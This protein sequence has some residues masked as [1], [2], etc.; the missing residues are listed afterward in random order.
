VKQ[1]KYQQDRN[2]TASRPRSKK[3]KTQAWLN[4]EDCEIAVDDILN[5]EKMD[6][7][8]DNLEIMIWE[9]RDQNGIR[10]EEVEKN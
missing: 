7:F 1:E 3:K 2:Y 6:E 5:N 10:N 4:Q 9:Y 8:L